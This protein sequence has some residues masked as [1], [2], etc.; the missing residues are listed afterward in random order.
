MLNTPS[1]ELS[2]A[3]PMDGFFSEETPEIETETVA[4]EEVEEATETEEPEVKEVDENEVFLIGDKEITLAQLKRLEDRAKNLESGFTKKVQQN[5]QEHKAKLAEVESFASELK[6]KADVIERILE[7]DEKAIDWD[8]LSPSELKAVE[9]K[10]QTRRNELE[11][12]RINA[13]KAAER[14][15][16]EKLVKANQDVFSRFTGWK[17]EKSGEKVRTEDL[18]EAFKYASSLGMTQKDIE[19]LTESWQFIALIEAAKFNKI[20]T[21]NPEAR[22]KVLPAKKAPTKAAQSAA[23]K[24]EDVWF[25]D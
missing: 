5:D 17:D 7:E 12:A 6:A 24:L 3:A 16:A 10:F 20:K 11:K 4:G 14:V 25:P 8:M 15:K 22:K 19:Q 23:P 2:Q 9:K 13:D 18:Q 1:Q 21:S